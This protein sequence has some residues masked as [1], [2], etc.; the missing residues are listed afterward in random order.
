MPRRKMR[1]AW[2]SVSKVRDGVWRV[3]Y[4]AEGRDGYRRRSETVRGTRRDAEERRSALMLE[5]GGDGPCPTVRECWERW[6]LPD[7]R[8]QVAEGERSDQTLAQYESRWRRHV[9]PRWGDVPADEVRPLAVQQWISSMPRSVA[10]QSAQVLRSTLAYAVRY[11]L[12]VA[13]PMD[14]DYVMPARSTSAERDR[15][16]W[17]VDGLLDAWSRLR[18]SWAEGAF[19]AMA[20]G[21]AR[22]AE[23]LGVRAEGVRLERVPVGGSEVSVAVV[24]IAAQVKGSGVPDARLK[25]RWSE[26]C[27]LVPG[28]AGERIAELAAERGEGWLTHDGEGA[29]SDKHALR[30]EWDAAMGGAPE[31]HPMKALRASWETALRWALGLPPWVTERLMG[32]V[33]VS[34]GRVTAYH[35]DSPGDADLV[36][37]VAEAYAAR[38][39]LEGA[40]LGPTGIRPLGASQPRPKSGE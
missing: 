31:R 13:N 16:T 30:H 10:Q 6:Y 27:A 14:A 2:G 33:P 8:W 25:N 21:G 20:F 9:G 40:G 24:P 7:L 29:P 37:A 39:V 32:H 23:S 35:Y 1:S 22:V 26:R 3:R 5:H 17:D 4:W 12:I 36:R 28:A 11:E 15:G 34:G 19:L 18:G 38:P